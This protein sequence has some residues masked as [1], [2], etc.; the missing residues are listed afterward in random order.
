MRENRTHGSEGGRNS[1]HTSTFDEVAKRAGSKP[2]GEKTL[3]A[4][5]FLIIFK[6]V[7]TKE[8]HNIFNAAV[9]MKSG[10]K[11]HSQFNHV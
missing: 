7:L 3:I 8:C 10:K 9:D 11:R 1:V 4:L 5:L 6:R 2:F